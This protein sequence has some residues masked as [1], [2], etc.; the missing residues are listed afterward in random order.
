[1][2]KYIYIIIADKFQQFLNFKKRIST[3]LMLEMVKKKWS[4]ST[5]YYT[6]THV[7]EVE[8]K[9]LKISAKMVARLNGKPLASES[10]ENENIIYLIKAMNIM[11]M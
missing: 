5:N 3:G 1:M 11:K 7:Y 8:L 2:V 10:M 4:I 6:V 9:V